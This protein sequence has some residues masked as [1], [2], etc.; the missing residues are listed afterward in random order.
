M[1]Y[2]T[3]SKVFQNLFLRHEKYQDILKC[4]YVLVSSRIYSSG[5]YKNIIQARNILYPN[6][7]VCSSMTNEIFKE[8]YLSQLES[9]EAFFATLIKGSIEEKFNI[10]FLDTYKEEKNMHFLE[11]LSEFIYIHFGYPCYDYKYYSLGLIPLI[12]YNRKEVLFICNDYLKEAKDNHNIK[13][14][15]NDKLRKYKKMKKKELIKILKK[16]GLYEVGMVKEEMIE[17]IELFLLGD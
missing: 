16:E 5:E 12:K 7:E 4:Q 13:E 14:G 8:K 17:S 9:N 6:A 15:K 1:L 10:V 3:N 2:Y 11:Y